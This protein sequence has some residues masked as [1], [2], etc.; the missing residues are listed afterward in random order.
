M[1]SDPDDPKVSFTIP[2]VA[3]TSVASCHPRL[4]KGRK[5]H[6]VSLFFLE[7]DDGTMRVV[8][9]AV[10]DI[11]MRVKLES[12]AASVTSSGMQFVSS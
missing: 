10:N 3:R 8:P 5:G 7:D 1:K 6:R 12:R 2:N 4:Y 9:Q 11:P